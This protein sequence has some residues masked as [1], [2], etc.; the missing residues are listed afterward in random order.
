M[1][2]GSNNHNP[3]LILGAG[4]TGLS[5]SISTGGTVLERHR[6]AGGICSSYYRAPDQS[7]VDGKYRFEYG[8]GHWIFGGDPQILSWLDK[9]SQTRVYQRHSAVYFPDRDLYVPYPLQNNL[10]A[11][12]DETA[13]LVLDE[14]R[15]PKTEK[16]PVTMADWLLRSFGETLCELFFFPFHDAYTAGLYKRIGP[17]D[18]YKSPVDLASVEAGA[19]DEVLPVGYNV[20]FRYPKRGLDNLVSELADGCDLRLGR[21]VVK[22]DPDSKE[23]VI[24]SGERMHY[25]RLISTLPLDK[26]LL[27][28][29]I[30]LDEPADPYTSVLV[31][32]IGAIAGP[33]CPDHHWLY[34]P[35]SRAGFHRV[36]F[37]NNVDDSFCPQ[38]SENGKRISLYVEKAFLSVDRPDESELASYQASVIKELRDWGYIG[39]VEVVDPTWVDVAYTWVWPDSK[40]RVKAMAAV[41][42]IGIELVG[43]YA[44]WRFQGIADSIRDGLAVS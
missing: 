41:E 32:N 9:L 24:S 16:I 14:L 38:S 6:V 15:A 5:A 1:K 18:P 34:I 7:N 30:A 27:L 29:G 19:R 26:T 17:Q 40:W 10:A 22:I 2:T 43:R 11:L 8:G 25:E 33:R 37:Y 39:D 42:E 4:V 3:T 23:V 35:H 36:G 12:G 13:Q 44:R 20:N 21:E 31:L 28:A